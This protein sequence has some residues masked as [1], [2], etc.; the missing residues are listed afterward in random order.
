MTSTRLGPIVENGRPSER[1]RFLGKAPD[2]SLLLVL[3]VDGEA[4]HSCIY[5]NPVPGGTGMWLVNQFP[6]TQIEKGEDRRP[7]FVHYT[8]DNEWSVGEVDFT[9]EDPHGYT[10]RYEEDWL[11]KARMILLVST[12]V[13]AG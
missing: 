13:S 11:G 12:L 5:H 7:H 10:W 1:V 4:M 2:G 6:I 9:A 3:G 8:T